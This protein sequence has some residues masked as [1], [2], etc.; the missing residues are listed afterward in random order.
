MLFHRGLE[1][2]A[3]AT[4]NANAFFQ[5]HQPWRMSEG[6]DKQTVLFIVYETIRIV[7]LLLQPIVPH[8]ADRTLKRFDF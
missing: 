2:L 3:S 6:P 5:L 8:Y 7:S 4:K 1:E